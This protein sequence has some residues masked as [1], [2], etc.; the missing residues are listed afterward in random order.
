MWIDRLRRRRRN[1]HLVIE[2]PGALGVDVTACGCATL[3]WVS[4]TPD[5]GF[6]THHCDTIRCDTHANGDNT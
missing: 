3:C 6:L 4:S 1:M 5:G 2:R